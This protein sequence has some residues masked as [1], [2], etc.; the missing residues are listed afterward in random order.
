MCNFISWIEREGRIYF[1]QNKDLK[2]KKF[3]EFKKMNGD[4]WQ[5]DIV[6]HGAIRHF[7]PELGSA[8]K[9]VE[10]EDFTKPSNFPE[11]IQS[12]IRGNR[13]TKF[14][15]M[16]KG[17]LRA[18]LYAEYEKNRNTLYA[19]YRK[20]RNTLYAEYRKNCAHLY[21]EYRKNCAHLYAEYEKNCDTLYAEAWF[22]FANQKNRAMAWKSKKEK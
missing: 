10:N 8:G 11:V 20:N 15:A 16:P 19:E 5:K 21:A 13:M 18:P 22:L 14:G 17:L 3:N 12:A 4:Q 2:G 7:Y 6:G 9:I 1:L